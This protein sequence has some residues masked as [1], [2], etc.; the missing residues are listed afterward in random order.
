MLVA[1]FVALAA[2]VTPAGADADTAHSDAPAAQ[3][4]PGAVVALGDSYSSGLGAGAYEDDCDRTPRAWAMLIFGD[5]VTDRTLLACSGAEVPQVRD[6]VDQLAGLSGE[7]GNRLITVTVGGNDV[8]FADELINCLTPLVSC[9]DREDVV[10]ERIDELREPLVDLYTQIQAAAPGDDIIVGGYPMLVPDPA[11]R[12]DCPALTGLL[13][14]DE[15]LMIRRLGIELNDAI[16]AAASEAG[17][18]SAAT[19]L[20]SAFEGHEACANG[21]DDWLYGLKIS[22]PGT[23][24]PGAKPDV[25]GPAAAPEAQA[26]FVSNSFH[27]NVPG[28][29]GYAQAFEQTW[30][31]G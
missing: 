13:S 7:S 14:A 1:A 5:A 20:E 18:R 22:W 2:A 6:Q 12:S 10:S 9:L 11:V 27:P 26:D 30:F 19:E 24:S 28:Q 8:G 3:A 29:A 23:E 25:A 17:V 31:S 21:P 4:T 16:D 15:R